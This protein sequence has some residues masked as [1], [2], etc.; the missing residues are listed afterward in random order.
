MKRKR[1]FILWEDDKRDLTIIYYYPPNNGYDLQIIRDDERIWLT[2]RQ[3]EFLL[4]VIAN[5]TPVI[6]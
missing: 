5:K 2:S 6:Y 3:L 1:E 4:D